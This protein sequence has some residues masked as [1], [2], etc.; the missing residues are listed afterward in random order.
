MYRKGF[1]LIELLVVIAII[2]ILAAMMMPAL[3]GARESATTTSCLNEAKQIGLGAQMYMMDNSEYIPR[4]YIGTNINDGLLQ[5]D[6]PPEFATEGQ[7]PGWTG[8]RYR[9]APPGWSHMGHWPN[10]VYPYAPSAAVWL[11][12]AW[13]AKEDWSVPGVTLGDWMRN[14]SPYDF[15]GFDVFVSWDECGVVH[16][17]A[18]G[19]GY[20]HYRISEVPK[21]GKVFLYTHHWNADSYNWGYCLGPAYWHG[22]HNMSRA[23]AMRLNRGSYPI[24]I[25]GDENPIFC[26]GH[27][28]TMTWEEARCFSGQNIDEFGRCTQGHV[29]FRDDYGPTSRHY[30]ASHWYGVSRWASCETPDPEWIVR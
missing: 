14:L 18:G 25:L 2:A 15:G 26:D 24:T 1:T 4:D 29:G 20:P 23:T 30:N 13:E 12:D 17:S 9:G 3:E 5:W 10:Q 16:R 6:P 27:V 7:L 28:E 8:P 22:C 21:A 11:C 19:T